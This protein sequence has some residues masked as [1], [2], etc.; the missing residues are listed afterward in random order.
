MIYICP[1]QVPYVNPGSGRLANDHR[2]MLEDGRRQNV[3]FA[4]Q[5]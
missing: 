4:L 3:G 2:M 1:W 5:G